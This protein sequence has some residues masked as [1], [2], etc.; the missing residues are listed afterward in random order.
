MVRVAR[1]CSVICVLEGPFTTPDTVPFVCEPLV[2]VKL[3]D[4]NH[5]C[6][7]LMKPRCAVVACGDTVTLT[8]WS[9]TTWMG[10]F[11]EL[12][13]HIWVR[14]SKPLPLTVM[15]VPGGPDI[16]ENVVGMGWG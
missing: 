2:T 4:V 13:I 11:L 16:G 14:P 5:E 12:P 8:I 15:T 9:L 1:P 10:E 6:C 3:A 7:G